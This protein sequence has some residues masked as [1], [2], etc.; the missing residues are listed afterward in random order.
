M[1]KKD[2]IFRHIFYMD[3]ND[4]HRQETIYVALSLTSCSNFESAT[5]GT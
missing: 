3:E 5:S 1:K 4:T 2:T